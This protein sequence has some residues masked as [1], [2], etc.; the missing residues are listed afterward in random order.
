[1]VVAGKLGPG[2]DV[3]DDKGG[4]YDGYVGGGGWRLEILRLMD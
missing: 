4:G 3:D 1:M 2:G